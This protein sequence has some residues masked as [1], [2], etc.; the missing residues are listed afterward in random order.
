MSG[1]VSWPAKKGSILH[2]NERLSIWKP[3]LHLRD[4]VVLEDFSMLALFRRRIETSYTFPDQII[5]FMGGFTV[6]LT[7]SAL[8]FS[9]TGWCIDCVLF[10]MT[11]WL[12]TNSRISRIPIF[13]WRCLDIIVIVSFGFLTGLD[14]VFCGCNPTPFQPG[15]KGWFPSTFSRP[16]RVRG[17]ILP[18]VMLSLVEFNSC[19]GDVL[20]CLS[21][22]FYLV[23]DSSVNLWVT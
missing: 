19:F 23:K 16:F 20:T 21:V 15:G 18:S 17:Y 1:E 14:D 5:T 10:S 7:Q 12:Q 8:N 11:L 9:P 4:S 3:V 6:G 2:K 13:H 22:Q